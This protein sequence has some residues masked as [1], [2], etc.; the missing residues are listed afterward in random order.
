MRTARNN[1]LIGKDK[2]VALATPGS[3]TEIAWS[4]GSGNTSSG[5]R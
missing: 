4:F 1:T 2:S 3:A 5:Q